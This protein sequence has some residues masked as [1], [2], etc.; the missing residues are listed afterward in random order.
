MNQ[1]SNAK[2]NFE[3]GLSSTPNEKLRKLKLIFLSYFFYFGPAGIQ[4]IWQS[5]YGNRFNS[6]ALITGC[7][8][9][10]FAVMPFGKNIQ[11][12]GVY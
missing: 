11:R 4:N 2:N 8:Q 12:F 6:L 5:I 1:K 3:R 9:L 10:F 7:N